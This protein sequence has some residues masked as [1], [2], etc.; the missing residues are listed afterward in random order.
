MG[1]PQKN[2]GAR[3]NWDVVMYK[4]LYI[5]HTYVPCTQFMLTIY[6]IARDKSCP[7][8][9]GKSQGSTMSMLSQAG[10]SELPVVSDGTYKL[11][12]RKFMNVTIES[13]L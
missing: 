11:T 10:S 2:K 13:R 1:H 9:C 6:I 3:L 7:R 5:S 8:G 4:H 12:C